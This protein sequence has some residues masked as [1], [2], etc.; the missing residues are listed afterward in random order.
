MHYVNDSLSV[1]H[2][3]F[4]HELAYH[5]NMSRMYVLSFKSGN[6]TKYYWSDGTLNA[7]AL[8]WGAVLKAI[9]G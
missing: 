7:A 8:R 3:V 9:F 2:L 4:V 5:I 6:I 1:L